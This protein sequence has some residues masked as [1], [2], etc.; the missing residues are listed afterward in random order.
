MRR[1]GSGPQPCGKLILPSLE[2]E[3]RNR[4]AVRSD[5]YR[6][7]QPTP[8]GMAD[9][10]CRVRLRPPG[11]GGESDPEMGAYPRDTRSPTDEGS[12]CGLGHGPA[13]LPV[14]R[15]PV[16]WWQSAGTGSAVKRSELG[17]PNPAHMP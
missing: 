13:V 16:G 4:E 2:R 5:A 1:V 3:K 10:V 7:L 8:L 17:N 15:H 12:G 6:S 9:T 14:R 11:A